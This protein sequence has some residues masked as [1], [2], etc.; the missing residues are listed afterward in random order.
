MPL[1]ILKDILKVTA[2]ADLTSATCSESEASNESFWED[3]LINDLN[4]LREL[5][6]SVALTLQEKSH[7]GE[8]VDGYLENA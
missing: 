1:Y 6:Y 3:D 2:D 5:V 4:N 8:E 7:W